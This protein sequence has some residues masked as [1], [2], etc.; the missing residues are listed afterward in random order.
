ME[1]ETSTALQ[2]GNQS[3]GAVVFNAATTPPP[4]PGVLFAQSRSLD[5]WHSRQTQ[6]SP[7]QFLSQARQ[8]HVITVQQYHALLRDHGAQ[9]EFTENYKRQL[10]TIA[11]S[12]ASGR[13][14]GESLGK[15]ANL[16]ST[17]DTSPN[18]GIHPSLR[19]KP[20]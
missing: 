10:G 20:A 11:E 1:Y 17:F 3:V 2:A 16:K 14:T 9:A 6:L 5:V 18:L 8:S 15:L 13:L 12:D 19:D 4:N 7:P